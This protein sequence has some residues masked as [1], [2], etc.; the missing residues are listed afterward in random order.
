MK[1]LLISLAMVLVLAGTMAVPA[2]AA[3]QSEEASVTVNEYISF[4]VTDNGATGIVFGSLDQATSDNPE[5]AQNGAGA[6][7]LSVATETNVDC[8][9]ETKGSADFSDGA[10]HTIPLSNAKWDTD[11]AVAG[12]TTMTTSYATIDTSTAGVLKSVEVYHWLSIPS[13]QYAATYTTNFFY[14]A[15]AP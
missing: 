8:V 13:G 3:E 12:A 2:M 6:V 9:I 5:A 15:V 4:T 1:R 7:T 10:T 11:N 14:Q